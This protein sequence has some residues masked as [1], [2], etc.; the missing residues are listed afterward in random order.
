MEYQAV[1]NRNPDDST[2]SSDP[3]EG[4]S[5]IEGTSEIRVGKHNRSDDISQDV[6]EGLP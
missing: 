1:A 4:K 5:R 6:D 3:R 2:L